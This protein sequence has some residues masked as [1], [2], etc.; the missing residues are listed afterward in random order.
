[1]CLGQRA[2]GA[3]AK[4]A[5]APQN[6]RNAPANFFFIMPLISSFLETG[7][8]ARHNPRFLSKPICPIRKPP[9]HNPNR[10]SSRQRPPHRQRHIRNQS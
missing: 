5:T 10:N 6:D 1:M 8:S 7:A 3:C 9:A 4:Q 2:G